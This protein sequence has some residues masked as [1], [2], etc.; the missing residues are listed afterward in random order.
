MRGFCPPPHH[1]AS[2]RIAEKFL[3]TGIPAA[4]VK[5]LEGVAGVK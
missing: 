2:R 4:G 5:K 1:G 3:K